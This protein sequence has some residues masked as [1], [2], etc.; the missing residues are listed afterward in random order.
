MKF[1]FLLLILFIWQTGQSQISA[2]A[3]LKKSKKSNKKSSLVVDRL[4]EFKKTKTIFVLSNIYDKAT[5]DS[6][7]KASWHV[8]PYEIVSKKK[9]NFNDYG[10]SQYSYALLNLLKK[11]FVKN[12]VPTGNALIFTEL[13]IIMYD[14]DKI[15]K[16]L[17]KM[18]PRRRTKKIDAVFE[19]NEINI[20]SFYL[21]PTG[22]FGNLIMEYNL[23]RTN[24]VQK[25]LYKDDVFL[26]IS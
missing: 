7:L 20:A 24:I 11:E 12:N 4:Q 6:I 19:K 18:S 23:D 14:F 17:D 8:T 22:E 3:H 26:T 2:R 25:K 1:K 9:F 16:V 15:K 10:G 21:Y 5:Y 13:D